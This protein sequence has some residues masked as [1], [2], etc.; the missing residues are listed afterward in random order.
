MSQ[1]TGNCD[2]QRASTLE[3]V[4]GAFRNVA[5]GIFSCI[6]SV[7]PSVLSCRFLLDRSFF[8]NFV[9]EGFYK[10][11]LGESSLYQRQTKSP[12]TSQSVRTLHKRSGQFTKSL[13]T[14]QRVWTLHTHIRSLYNV[15]RDVRNSAVRRIIH[16]CFRVP[17]LSI[18]CIVDSD[19]RLKNTKKYF[20]V[21]MATMGIR[22]NIKLQGPVEM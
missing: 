8:L 19:M 7:F 12:D 22:H 1:G 11:R 2:I 13:D 15:C 3:E 9:L 6:L 18:F 10:I 21:Q 14:P 5:S 4:L 17:T 16:Y 20:Y